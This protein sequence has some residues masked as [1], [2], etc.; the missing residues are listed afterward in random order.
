MKVDTR[1][2]ASMMG[3]NKGVVGSDHLKTGSEFFSRFP[4]DVPELEIASMAEHGRK[5]DQF[6]L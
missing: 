4:E 2:Q 3:A 6:M 1:L 5:H